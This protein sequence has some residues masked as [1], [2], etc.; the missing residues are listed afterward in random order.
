MLRL[1]ATCETPTGNDGAIRTFAPANGDQRQC[2]EFLPPNVLTLSCKPPHMPASPRHG[3]GRRLRRSGRE[4]NA[5]GVTP[6]SSE[7]PE[8]A[9]PPSQRIGGL[10]AC[11]GS[12]AATP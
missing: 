2:G 9:R 1:E 11:E 7:P 12:W 8:A 6:S 10:A 3:G 5:A 4:S